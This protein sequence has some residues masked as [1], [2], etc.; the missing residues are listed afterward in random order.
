MPGPVTEIQAAVTFLRSRKVTVLITSA[1]ALA[2]GELTVPAE[3]I[4]LPIPGRAT[5]AV[6]LLPLLIA[7]TWVACV[8]PPSPDLERFLPGRVMRLRR[9]G[10]YLLATAL[11]VGAAGG[12]LAARFHTP[13]AGAV[14]ARSA[15]IGIAL[16]TAS[17]LVLP[18]RMAWLPPMTITLAIWLYGT[19][20]LQGTPTWWAVPLHP[21][22]S[23]PVAAATV[24]GWVIAGTIYVLVDARPLA[25]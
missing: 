15:L 3:A 17:A 16:A 23:L 8:A 1:L 12:T 13:L 6:Y 21:A 22:D 9:C 18:T 4:E 24:L 20:D 10:W 14:P 19:T 2:V 7:T 5:V 25:D 11:W